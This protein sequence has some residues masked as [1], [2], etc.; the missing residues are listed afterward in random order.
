MREPT[1]TELRRME[2]E[3]VIE[4]IDSSPWL[5]NLAVS[6]IRDGGV[7]ICINMTAVAGR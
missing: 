1:E 7:R 2:A 4:L 3:G 6:R 5:S